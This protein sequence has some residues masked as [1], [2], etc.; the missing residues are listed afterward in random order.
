MGAKMEKEKE[1]EE[2]WNA[3]DAISDSSICPR[4]IWMPYPLPPPLL[5]PPFLPPIL[6]P[7]KNAFGLVFLSL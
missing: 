5:R 3:C 4:R 1:E 6:P 7:L 2:E